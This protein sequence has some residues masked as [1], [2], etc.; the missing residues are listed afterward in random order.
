MSFVSQKGK[1]L[2]RP[3]L[4]R[5][6]AEAGMLAAVGL[7]KPRHPLFSLSSPQLFY[8]FTPQGL[9]WTQ[10][11]EQPWNASSYVS[12]S[13]RNSSKTFC[14]QRQSLFSPC[15]ICISSPKDVSYKS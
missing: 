2:P 11:H 8:S 1:R 5:L 14:S 4:S 10:I 12:G 3:E 7:L 6:E 15:P 13:G 9:T